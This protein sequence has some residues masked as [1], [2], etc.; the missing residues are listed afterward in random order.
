VITLERVATDEKLVYNEGDVTH[1]RIVMRFHLGKQD[2]SDFDWLYKFGQEHQ[3]LV[4]VSIGT[5]VG[6]MATFAKTVNRGLFPDR[7]WWI[8]H[9]C[10][11]GFF[12]VTSAYAAEVFSLSQTGTAFVNSVLLLLGFAAINAIEKRFMAVI[13][14][15]GNPENEVD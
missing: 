7:R 2:M 3:T 11:A 13:E 5:A 10:T 8:V 14:G 15:K 9:S 6:L 12:A 4:G 1:M